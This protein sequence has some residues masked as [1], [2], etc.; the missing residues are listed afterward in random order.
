MRTGE[1]EREEGAQDRQHDG[2]PAEGSI[3]FRRHTDIIEDVARGSNRSPG[4]DPHVLIRVI[5]DELP[6]RLAEGGCRWRGTRSSP[7]TG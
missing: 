7:N 4:R 1:P 2:M 5:Y 6:N 3:R